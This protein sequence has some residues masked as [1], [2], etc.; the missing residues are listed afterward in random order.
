MD[1]AQKKTKECVD[2][3]VRIVEAASAEPFPSEFKEECRQAMT[4][5]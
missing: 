4:Y 5:F 2:K 1:M 3:L